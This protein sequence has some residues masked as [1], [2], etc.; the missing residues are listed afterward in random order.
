[1]PIIGVQQDEPRASAE[2]GWLT[3]AAAGWSLL[4]MGAIDLSLA[5]IPPRI[6]QPDWEFGTISAMLNSL[7]VPTIGAALALGASAALGR[8][9][10][11]GA[12]AAWS[13]LVCLF[14]SVAVVLYVL[15]IPLAL[16]AVTDPVPRSALTA[17]MAKSLCSVV[18]YGAVH[19]WFVRR[20]ALYLRDR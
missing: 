19:G 8:R 17:A 4:L 2:T 3:L 12:V 10:A 13:A 6:G 1:M 9:G 7:P 14:L 16:R 5:W 15:D 18:V 20:A 11:V